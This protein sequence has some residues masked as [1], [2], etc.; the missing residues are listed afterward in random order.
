MNFDTQKISKALEDG[1]FTKKQTQ[2][3]ITALD[4]GG[5][6]VAKSDLDKAVSDIYLEIKDSQISLIKWMVPLIIGYGT[7]IATLVSLFS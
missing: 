5:S 3:I 6:N 2:E 1:G 4:T 7:L